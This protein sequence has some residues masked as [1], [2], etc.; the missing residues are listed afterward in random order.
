M[1]SIT[2]ITLTTGKVD[3]DNIKAVTFSID[4]L[5]VELGLSKV[6]NI[7]RLGFVVEY[8]EILPFDIVEKVVNKLFYKG[9]GFV[10]MNAKE[11]LLRFNIGANTSTK[12]L[13]ILKAV[14]LVVQFDKNRLLYTEILNF[15]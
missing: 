11:F 3:R 9:P 14:L 10:K 4:D 8:S 15:L 7:I 5:E 12:T 2:N 1:Y 13:K 6:D